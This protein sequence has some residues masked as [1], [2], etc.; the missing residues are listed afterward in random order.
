MQTL[1]DLEARNPAAG[2]G[3]YQGHSTGSQQVARS[4]AAKD[5]EGFTG[6]AQAQ[7]TP[8]LRD[9]GAGVA[10]EQLRN[11]NDFTGA[12]AWAL[13]ISDENGQRSALSNAVS[14]WASRDRASA[15]RWFEETALPEQTRKYLA[16]NFPATQ[17]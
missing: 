11:S 5:L 2:D 6:W 7:A 1:L 10:S 4:W 17:Q 8:E 13:R 15:Q 16:P 12:A 3:W 9:M 14:H